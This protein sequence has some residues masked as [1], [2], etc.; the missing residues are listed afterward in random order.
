MS[1]RASFW[2]ARE[3]LD[4]AGEDLGVGVDGGRDRDMD[5][6]GKVWWENV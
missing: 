5:R 3:V 2:T 4:G 6:G 1:S